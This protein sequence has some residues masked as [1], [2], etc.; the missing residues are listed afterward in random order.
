MFIATIH[1][2][3][4]LQAFLDGNELVKSLILYVLNE[5]FKITF[6]PTSLA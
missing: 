6:T 5:A 3:L 2:F 1:H 4:M